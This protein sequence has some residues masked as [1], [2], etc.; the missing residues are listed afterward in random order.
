[1]V[2]SNTKA[3]GRA[4]GSRAGARRGGR[5]RAPRPRARPAPPPTRPPRSVRSSTFL[6]RALVFLVFSSKRGASHFRRHR[7]IDGQRR[8]PSRLVDTQ[9][10][11]RPVHSNAQCTQTHRPTDRDPCF[12]RRF[13]AAHRGTLAL[14]PSL[15]PPRGRLAALSRLHAPPPCCI[16][17]PAGGLWGL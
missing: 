7:N 8:H 14:G 1:M 13:L 15:H 12:S 11:G 4:R 6:T 5:A 9:G 17:H 2:L 16:L 3:R 10:G